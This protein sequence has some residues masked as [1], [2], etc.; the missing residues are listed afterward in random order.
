[1]EETHFV[2]VWKKPCGLC[3]TGNIPFPIE[4]LQGDLMQTIH[5][6]NET[7]AVWRIK[8][9]DVTIQERLAN[10]FGYR[11]Q[12]ESVVRRSVLLNRIN[13]I[14]IIRNDIYPKHFNRANGLIIKNE[15]KVRIIDKLIGW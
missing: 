5:L 1:M 11:K 2:E 9:T 6:G 3:V 14:T 7:V 13:K 10:R 4:Y 15:R 12:K 8:G